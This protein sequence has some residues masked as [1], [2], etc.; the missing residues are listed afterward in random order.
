MNEVVGGQ[1]MSGVDIAVLRAD[2]NTRPVR[3]LGFG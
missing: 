1:S 3:G 2:W